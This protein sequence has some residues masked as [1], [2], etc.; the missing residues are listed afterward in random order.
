MNG[1]NFDKPSDE[2]RAKSQDRSQ[3]EG[4][5]R[6]AMDEELSL[7]LGF[8]QEDLLAL[9]TWQM[10]F[11]KYAGRPLITLPEEYLF[12]FRK[13]G[14]PNDRLGKLM[15]L[16]LELKIEGLDGLLT[17]LVKSRQSR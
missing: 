10:P 14:F 8:D 7:A 3:A 1:R 9:A 12:W 16:C 5:G 6:A 4:V 11:G 15:A 17:P 13:H 2:N